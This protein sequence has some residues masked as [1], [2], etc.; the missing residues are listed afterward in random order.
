MVVNVNW[1]RLTVSVL[2]ARRL[3]VLNSKPWTGSCR[4]RFEFKFMAPNSEKSFGVSPT[5]QNAPSGSKRDAV[6]CATTELHASTHPRN[7]KKIFTQRRCDTAENWGRRLLLCA[8]APR[9]E[10]S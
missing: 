8:A 9:R 3:P 10:N 2:K 7:I 6:F 5:I 4:D 1:S